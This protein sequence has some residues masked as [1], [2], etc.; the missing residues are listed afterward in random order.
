M[1]ESEIAEYFRDEW[2][3]LPKDEAVV[4][5]GSRSIL[6]AFA[7]GNLQIILK[8]AVG[9]RG[10]I[11]LNIWAHDPRPVV[12]AD[13][14]VVYG[15][16]DDDGLIELNTRT[17]ADRLSQDPFEFCAAAFT[18]LLGQVRQEPA[19]WERRFRTMPVASRS[20]TIVLGGGLPGHGKRQ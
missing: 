10:G 1:G 16:I 13:R 11:V 19:Y 17:R 7:V 2:A 9:P 6:T 14:V 5:R 3:D 4:D 15:T 8:A 12:L 18:K 20:K